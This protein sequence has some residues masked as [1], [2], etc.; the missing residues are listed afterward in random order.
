MS[1]HL[2][3]ASAILTSTTTALPANF[4]FNRADTCTSDQV[5]CSAAFPSNFCCNAD[6]KCISL[7]GNTTV[8]CCPDGVEGAC[9][10]IAPVTCDVQQQNVDTHPDSRIKTTIFDVPLAACGDGEC[11]PFGYSCNNGKCFMN[12]D[13]SKKPT[14]S[15]STT[16]SAPTS[17]TSTV[18]DTSSAATGETTATD[19]TS[20]SSSQP[21]STDE[22]SS[23]TA[24]AAADSTGES[25]NK[26][27][28]PATTS[29][30]GGVVGAVLL[31]LI[32]GII[33]FF[34]IRRKKKADSVRSEKNG[35]AYGHGRSPSSNGSFGNIISEPIAQPNSFRTDF[36]RKSPSNS[37]STPSGTTPSRSSPSRTSYSRAS[38]LM[39]SA[40]TII[41]VHPTPPRI[42]I[43]IPNPFNSPNPSPNHNSAQASPADDETPRHGTVRL[44]PIRAMRASSHCSRRPTTPELQREPS[45]E[46]INVFAEPGTVKAR[47]LTRGTTFT[48]L[49]DEADLG[50][51]RRG[52]PYVPGTTPRI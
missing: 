27:G 4:I 25:K 40:S 48:D 36:I 22:T 16:T 30:V 17:V 33:I 29:I 3:L 9:N 34:Y 35:H 41:R 47:P 37:R 19:A 32:V 8:V 15:S 1:L 11:C 28:G 49:M 20:L 18:S 5:S 6:S 24:A 51:V 12:K 42:R 50:A 13:Q 46:S 10:T 45:S 31:L 52:S 26:D 2:L 44:A 14:A 38:T 23:T 43:S 21:T 7:A 39:R